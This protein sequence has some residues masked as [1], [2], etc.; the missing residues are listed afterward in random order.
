MIGTG[1]AGAI[2]A[3][4]QAPKEPLATGPLPGHTGGM[5]TLIRYDAARRALAAAHRVDE[6]KA[7]G[8]D[9]V[10]GSGAQWNGK[11]LT[12]TYVSPWQLWATIT[13]AQYVSLPITTATVSVANPAGMSAEFELQ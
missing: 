11:S 1:W 12:T 9:F 4:E 6:V 8:T 3:E 5:T 10:S 2:I 13:S 7:T